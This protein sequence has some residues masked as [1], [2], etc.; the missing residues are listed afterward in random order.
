MGF[1]K[2]H[3]CRKKEITW[4]IDNNGCW[5]CTSHAKNTDGYPKHRQQGKMTLISHTMYINYRGEISQGMCV[6]H[7]CDNPACINPDHLFLGTQLDNLA[8]R[9]YK[10]RQSKGE[11]HSKA[12]IGKKHNLECSG[13]QNSNARLTA[14]QVKEIKY[15]P[16][17][18]Y[19]KTAKIY[20]VSH[21]TIA[22]I[23]KGETWKEI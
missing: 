16:K 6:C 10:N 17:Y 12:C 1:K 8:D 7:K 3:T 9:D 19:K 18:G 15:N 20:G 21:G 5:N 14:K 22:F 11:K 13:E 4:K 2:G 23:R